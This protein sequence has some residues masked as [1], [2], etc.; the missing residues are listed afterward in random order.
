MG[1]RSNLFFKS[2]P[3]LVQTTHPPSIMNFNALIWYNC[4]LL[5]KSNVVIIDL[6]I[7]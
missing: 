3:V 1:N 5:V 4:K 2:L 6:N 7:P